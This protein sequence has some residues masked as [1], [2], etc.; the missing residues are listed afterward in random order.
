MPVREAT[1][2]ARKIPALALQLTFPLS[3]SFSSLSVKWGEFPALHTPT[4]N[5]KDKIA[6]V[7]F[8]LL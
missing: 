1:V 4:E 6:V 3:P 7:S 5:Y 2:G 8:D